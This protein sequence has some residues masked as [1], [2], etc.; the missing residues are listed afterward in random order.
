MVKSVK[1]TK[2]G[3]ILLSVGVCSPSQ[4][5]LDLDPISGRDNVEI[6]IANLSLNTYYVQGTVLINHLTWIIW[7][8]LTIT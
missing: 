5:D 2:L 7:L 4:Q 6:L 3:K 8:F 1:R